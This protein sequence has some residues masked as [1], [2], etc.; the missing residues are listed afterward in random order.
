M[1]ILFCCK[2][3][4]NMLQK[5]I[6]DWTFEVYLLTKETNSWFPLIMEN[7]LCQIH[8]M[9]LEFLSN[10][11]SLDCFLQPNI[12]P[13]HSKIIVTCPKQE[14]RTSRV[15]FDFPKISKMSINFDLFKVS[16][17][18]SWKIYISS[19]T[20][21]L[22]TPNFLFQILCD[23]KIQQILQERKMLLW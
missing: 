6:K 1:H 19:V 9:V 10:G 8:C 14:K 2:N 11:V 12:L 16:K 13:K 21:K 15:N 22:E 23:H 5:E 20:E 7:D 3:Q 17:M 4:K 18:T